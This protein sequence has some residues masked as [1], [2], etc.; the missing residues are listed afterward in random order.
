MQVTL[1][2]MQS[3]APTFQVNVPVDYCVVMRDG[4][5]KVV[6]ADIQ[7]FSISLAPRVHR[8]SLRRD[9]VHIFIDPIS[10]VWMGLVTLEEIGL[11][12]QTLA[13]LKLAMQDVL[14]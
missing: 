13:V 1:P 8:S 7:Y 5:I 14:P 4:L 12:E 6:D 11:S 9:V 3:P 2:L 10:A